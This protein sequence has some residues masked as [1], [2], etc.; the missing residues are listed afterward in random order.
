MAREV[1]RSWWRDSRFLASSPRCARLRTLGMT[2][3]WDGC[4]GVL[5]VVVANAKGSGSL[6]AAADARNDKGLLVLPS[7]GADCVA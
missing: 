5:V 7:A 3:A 2:K 4:G 1:R 6:F